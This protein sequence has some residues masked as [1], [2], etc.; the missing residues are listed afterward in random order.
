MGQIGPDD[1]RPDSADATE[2][3]RGYL[4]KTSLPQAP[5]EAPMLVVPDD[6]GGLIPWQQTAAALAR[7]CGMGDVIH[8]GA[9]DADVV[10]WINDRFNAVPPGNDCGNLVAP[11]PS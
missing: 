11:T 8:V 6:G 5:T 2:A 3:L 7:A 9:Q 1:L 4:Q 10:S